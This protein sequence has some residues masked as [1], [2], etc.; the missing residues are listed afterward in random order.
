MEP[1][2]PKIRHVTTWLLRRP[3][4]AE[5]LDTWLARAASGGAGRWCCDVWL[6]FYWVQSSVQS[7][8]G[9][10]TGEPLGSYGV[11]THVWFLGGLSWLPQ[12]QTS[13]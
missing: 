13:R 10:G 4:G 6:T 11:S 9:S 8:S 3:T 2:P 12:F 7:Q 1:A 5:T